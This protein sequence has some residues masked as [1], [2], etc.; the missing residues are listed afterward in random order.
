L[1]LLGI[2]ADNCLVIGKDMKIE[3]LIVDLKKNGLNM[4]IEHDLND[5]LI[6]LIIEDANLNQI[7]ILQPHFINSLEARF[8]KEVES[9]RVLDPK[10]QNYLS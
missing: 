9:K 2:Y 7:L 3:K 5:Y 6:C 1:A 8:G 4:K 10:V